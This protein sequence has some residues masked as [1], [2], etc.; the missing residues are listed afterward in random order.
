MP[1]S[2]PLTRLRRLDTSSSTFQDQVSNILYGKEYER[3]EPKLQGDDLTGLVDYL[4]KVRR[5]VSL[6][7]SPLRPS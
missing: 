2:N 3:W 4:D 1:S 6:L 5:R 7:R